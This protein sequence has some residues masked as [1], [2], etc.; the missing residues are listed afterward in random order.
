MAR[1]DPQM[2]LRIPEELKA[3]IDQESR[4]NGSSQNSEVVRAIRE[5]KDLQENRL[6]QRP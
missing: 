1:S 2:N 4:R 6:K 3:W 5:R